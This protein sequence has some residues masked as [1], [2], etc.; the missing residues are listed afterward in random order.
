MLVKRREFARLGRANGWLEGFVEA[1]Y[2]GLYN[3]P[4]ELTPQR[5]SK[6]RMICREISIGLKRMCAVHECNFGICC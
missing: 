5:P 6:R 3:D 2:G 4:M 1:T